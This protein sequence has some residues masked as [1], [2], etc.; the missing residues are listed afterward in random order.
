M[1]YA[2]L[3]VCDMQHAVVIYSFLGSLGSLSTQRTAP[4]VLHSSVKQ[5]N[6]TSIMGVNFDSSAGR[7]P[8]FSPRPAMKAIPLLLKKNGMSDPISALHS[9]SS[10]LLAGLPATKLAP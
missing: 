1:L 7:S 8:I 2:V 9:Y 3:L 10:L 4:H 5:K 6:R